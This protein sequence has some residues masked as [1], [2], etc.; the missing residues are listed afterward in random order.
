MNPLTVAR[1][2]MELSLAFHIVFSALGIGMPLL[3]LMA[4][5]RFLRTGE[6]H[7]RALARVWGKATALLFVVGAVS[8]TALS[9]ELGLL[10]PKFMA[11]AG[12]AL[13]PAFALEGYA[14]L[15]EAIFLGLYLYGWDRLSPRAHWWTGVPVAVSGCVSGILVVGANAWMQSPRGF[16]V[17]GGKIVDLDPFAVF[18]NPSWL[19]LAAHS[20]FACYAAVGFAVAGVYALG[21]LRGRTTP[22]HRAGL[23]LAMLMG[24]VAAVLQPLTGDRLAKLLF[25]TQPAKLAAMEAH[26]HTAHGVGLLVGGLPDPATG[27]VKYGIHL[28][29]MLS[30]MSTGDFDAKIVG[31]WDFPP[32]QRPNVLVCHVAFQLMVGAGFALAGLGALWAFLALRKVELTAASRLG[33]LV[34][35]AIAACA[36]LGFLALEAGWF[37]TEAGRQPWIIH[38]V[39]RT[40]DAVTP[41]DDVHVTFALYAV[42]YV[43]LAV[44]LIALLRALARKADEPPRPSIPP[45]SVPT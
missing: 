12:P 22:R 5:L 43:G 29:K 27:T 30:F 16:T 4:E 17:V 37:V 25:H 15:A 45:A 13:G 28:P 23:R 44:A 31:L 21:M 18:R 39:M 38:G 35:L 41:R 1:A 33:R 26:F 32:D 7:Y 11:F 10:W 8:G 24:T 40:A 2:Q 6:E 20:T 34:L 14:F 3:M 36:P 42:L 9:F 19:P